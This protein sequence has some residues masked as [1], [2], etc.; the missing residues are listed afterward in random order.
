MAARKA[1]S[2]K[3]RFEV[4]KRDSFTCQY[5]GAKAP[6]VILHIDHIDPV[7]NGGGNEILNLV[8]SCAE[9]NGGKSSRRLDDASVVRRQHEQLADLQERRNQM[10]MILQWQRS[11]ASIEVDAANEALSF[12]YELVPGLK[13]NQN[14][15]AYIDRLVKKHGLG[16][17][18][19]AMRTAKRYIRFDDTGNVTAESWEQAFD[20][21]GRIIRVENDAKTNPFARDTAY[22][23][24]ILKKRLP[25]VNFSLAGNNL[26]AAFS[27]GVTFEEARAIALSAKNY[28]SFNQDLCRAIDRAEEE[29]NGS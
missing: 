11:M 28:G 5:C 25:Y 12:W 13:A 1:L 20:A 19:G 6:D 8:T 17:V 24:G 7:A 14:G 10:D 4:F 23:I 27:W 22:I 15:I 16:D 29:S 21:I 18:I 2:P 26:N 9:C 3:T